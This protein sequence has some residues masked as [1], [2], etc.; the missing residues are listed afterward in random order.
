MDQKK[1]GDAMNDPIQI[2]MYS[3]V[4]KKLTVAFREGLTGEGCECTEIEKRGS[5]W[6]FA[7]TPPDKDAALKIIMR[8]MF[9]KYHISKP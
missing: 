2:T 1:S 7:A 3:R 5:R 4:S 8:S 6:A 9:Y